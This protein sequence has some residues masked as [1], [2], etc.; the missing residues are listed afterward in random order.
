VEVITADAKDGAFTW[1]PGDNVEEG[2]TYAFQVSQGDQRNYSALLR[3]GPQVPSA[4]DSTTGTTSS[5]TDATSSGTSTD[6]TQTTATTSKPL[7]SSSASGTPSSSPVSTSVVSST[8]T[9]ERPMLTE[10][11]TQGKKAK[12]EVQN[13][14]SPLEYSMELV[15]GALGLLVY[16]VQ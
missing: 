3:A 6:A 9:A 16:L 11:V 14:G 10:S 2:Q 15:G 5:A 13:A 8:V 4:S 1:T 12:A 7:I